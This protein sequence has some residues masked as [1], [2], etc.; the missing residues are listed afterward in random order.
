MSTRHQNRSL[1]DLGKKPLRRSELA[2]CATGRAYSGPL[3]DLGKKN[4]RKTTES[5]FAAGGRPESV[6]A[7]AD[8]FAKKSPDRSLAQE[9]Q[10]GW[11]TVLL[12]VVS[13]V[14]F[15]VLLV[16]FSYSSR[17]PAVPPLPTTSGQDSS[18][19]LPQWGASGLPRSQEE[20]IAARRFE[21]QSVLPTVG[22]NGRDSLLAKP[23]AEAKGLA[24][25]VTT[26]PAAIP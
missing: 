22:N 16:M 14:G 13:V 24:P 19:P 25:D 4:T 12:T 1:V 15:V 7:D 3:I 26:E 11:L 18:P 8:S 6:R 20:S 17:P 2:S 9:P 23:G 10:H 21:N 5:S